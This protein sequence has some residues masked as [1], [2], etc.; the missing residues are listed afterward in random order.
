MARITERDFS[1]GSPLVPQAAELPS[2]ALCKWGGE[3]ER[4]RERKRER[5]GVF[6]KQGTGKHQGGGGGGGGSQREREG[7]IF[8]AGNR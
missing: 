7:G 1:F 4:E 8:E 3:R 2:Y 5:R 6:V